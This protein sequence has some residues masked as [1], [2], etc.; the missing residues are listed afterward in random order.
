MLNIWLKLKYFFLK[1]KGIGYRN[2]KK[3]G[4][5]IKSMLIQETTINLRVFYIGIDFDL[6][7]YKLVNFAILYVCLYSC[8]GYRVYAAHLK[9]N[10]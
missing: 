2:D 8:L 4:Y 5:I 6:Q 9:C 1:V 3:E 10:K 7:I